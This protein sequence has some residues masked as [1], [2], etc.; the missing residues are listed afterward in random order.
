MVKCGYFH[1][2]LA[3]GTQKS[4]LCNGYRTSG[5]RQGVTPEVRQPFQTPKYS[6][7]V[8]QIENS[9]GVIFEVRHPLQAQIIITYQ[10]V[11]E[12]RNSMGEGNTRSPTPILIAQIFILHWIPVCGASTGVVFGQRIK[13]QF[14]VLEHML[15]GGYLAVGIIIF[16]LILKIYFSV[17]FGVR[18]L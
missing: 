14:F 16:A 1:S 4:S 10:R 5:I 8:P 7:W 17:H 18:S 15:L 3:S 9:M 6:Y 13:Y 12:I 11:S 2:S